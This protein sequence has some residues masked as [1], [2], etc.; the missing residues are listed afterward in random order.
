MKQLLASTFVYRFQLLPTPSNNFIEKMDK[1]IHNYVW[2]GRRHRLRKSLLSQPTS[3]GGLG[4]VNIHIQ[5]RSL[6]F[7]WFNRML[8]DTTHV[9]F[10]SAHL[11]HC[12]VIPLCDVLNCNLHPNQ[13]Q[14]VQRQGTVLPPFWIDV[15]TSWFKQCFISVDCDTCESKARVLAL[16]VVFN[17]EM[18]MNH[19]WDSPQLHATLKEHDVLLMKPFL[20]KFVTLFANIKQTD[21][22][23]AT[24]VARLRTIVLQKWNTIVTQSMNPDIHPPGLITDKFVSRS[25]N[26]Q[27]FYTIVAPS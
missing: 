2:E 6:K 7:A 26:S 1:E 16:P 9:Q 3:E 14:A 10:W 4:M 12:F 27:S 21:P 18:T 20:T 13:L 25:F 22:A 23:L 15:F 19:V 17:T 11:T 24:K 5:N 8:S